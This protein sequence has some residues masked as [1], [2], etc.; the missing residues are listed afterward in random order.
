MVHCNNISILQ[1]FQDTATFSVHKTA[2]NTE[3]SF[4]YVHTHRDNMMLHSVQ[5]LSIAA[6]LT[7]L[8]AA[9]TLQ[10]TLSMTSMWHILAC[11]RISRKTTHFHGGVGALN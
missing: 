11:L 7:G 8:I 4:V 2:F 6:Q 5:V 1:R 9:D 3:K 10:I